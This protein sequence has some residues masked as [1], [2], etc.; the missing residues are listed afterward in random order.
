MYLKK[1]ISYN[2]HCFL[3]KIDKGLFLHFV[4]VT[5][6]ILTLVSC[7][8]EGFWKPQT[9]KVSEGFHDPIGFYDK[10]PTFSWRL[11]VN[12]SISSQSAYRIVAASDSL[13][14][15]YNADIWDSK[16]TSANKSTWIKYEG[17]ELNSRKK[18]FWQVQCWDQS[19]NASNW[20]NIAHF[21]LGLLNNEDWK[22][23]W[24]S[25]PKNSTIDSTPGEELLYQPQYIAKDFTISDDI[26]YA[27]LYI[28]SKGV[29]EA[30]ING[31]KVGNDL[32]TPGWTAYNKRIETLTYDITAHLKKGENRIGALLGEGW[33]AGRLG[34][35]KASWKTKASPRLLAQLE[36]NYK[37][38][39]RKTILTD[40]TWK[41]TREGPLRYSGIYDGEVYDATKELLGW[42]KSGYN[43]DNW[44]FVEEIPI[45]KEIKLV[46][47]RHETVKDK[48]RLVAKT[49]TKV[50]KGKIIFDFGQNLAGVP[51]LR[52]PV[53]KGEKVTIRFAE[54]LKKD[55]TLYTEN[56]RTAKSTDYYIPKTNGL[57][58][59]KPK[60][61]F[62]GFRYVEISGYDES[63][64]PDESWVLAVAQHSDFKSNGNFSSSNEKLNQL[65]SNINWSLKSNFFDIPTDCPQ[66]DERL[67]WT[68]DAQVFAPT[69]IFNADV[70]AFWASWLNTMR[71]EQEDNGS[72]PLV[73][74]NVLGNKFS[75]GWADAATVVPWELYLRTGDIEILEDNFDM[76]KKLV[77]YYETKA[78][79][80][81][82][83]V[84]SFCDWLQPYSNLDDGL[85]AR[86]GDTPKELVNT[87][88][89][90]RSVALTLKAANVLNRANDVNYL[91][92]LLDSIK[93][94]F[95]NSFLN[96]NGKLK[97][98]TE[99]QTGYLMA[100]GFD[101]VS[102]E[103]ANKIKPY[104]IR[105]INTANN[106]LR[107][108]FLGT[109]LLPKVME[110]YKRSDLMYAILM[111]E[112]YPSWFY[113]INQGATTMWERWDSYS[114]L[115]GF[116][117]S[118]MNSFNHY[119]Y[120][121]IGQWMY[122]G[123]A[124]IRPLEAGY[125][126]ILIQPLIGRKLTE[127]AASYDSMY[128]IISTS[129]KKTESSFSIDITI[130]PNTTAKVVL[131]WNQKDKINLNGKALLESSENLKS[132]RKQK[133]KIELEIAAGTFTFKIF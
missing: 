90:G 99:T 8:S 91:K 115:N 33:F 63:I 57:I 81:I 118:G 47:K 71:D 37:N 68:G 4:L 65:Q 129:W 36:I 74:P 84:F 29:F 92:N 12:N 72:I 55:G 103:M 54:M 116:S 93:I 60:F 87:A 70:Y 102:K 109:P 10:K 43:F 58:H 79:K 108:G 59:Y 127:A 98:S 132:V 46:P 13:L 42:N 32:M 73:I 50:E 11:P 131:P 85:D 97:T 31:E 6:L 48:N 111:K 67:G 126:K 88:Y 66:R 94:A 77:S 100:V 34:W 110:Y 114:S 22:A 106:H 38:G 20:S 41:A 5:L 124:G 56:Y 119:A 3:F 120:G 133:T 44:S 125:K 53:K 35:K 86:F 51:L 96:E 122:E 128:G 123:I 24:I 15:P 28:T 1:L 62:H 52:I 45:D 104:L 16:K 40:A 121:A 14:L 49:I 101:L 82:P 19:D 25:L 89:Y 17:N 78:E 21:E 26:D 117:K 9:L 130:P 27:R 69:S 80:S 23:K 83:N 2:C 113:S 39:E 30:S 64:K 105:Q 61:T 75:S 112:T 95:Q 18:V 107:T 7:N 76:M